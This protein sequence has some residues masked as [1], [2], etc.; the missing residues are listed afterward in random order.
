MSVQAVIKPLEVSFDVQYHKI[1][2]FPMRWHMHFDPLWEQL[3]RDHNSEVEKK[4]M[5]ACCTDGTE[6]KVVKLEN[7]YLI[8]GFTFIARCAFACLCYKMRI[9]ATMIEIIRILFTFCMCFVQLCA[10]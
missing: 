7:D 4:C 1:D 8:N 10:F 9:R 5:V 3:A 2:N 6:G